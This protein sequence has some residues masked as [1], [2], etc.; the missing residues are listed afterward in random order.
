MGKVR[1]VEAE[2]VQ[3]YIN[4]YYKKERITP[5]LQATYEAEYRNRGYIC[6]SHHDNILNDFIA[7]PHHPLNKGE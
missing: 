6:T 4:K 1:I 3:D 7:W 2:S 5:T